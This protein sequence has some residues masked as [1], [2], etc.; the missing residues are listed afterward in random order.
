MYM[1]LPI[2][3]LN[4]QLADL[5]FL[6]ITD[7]GRLII[8]G[9]QEVDAGEYTCIASNIAGNTSGVVTLEVGCKYATNRKTILL[10][11]CPHVV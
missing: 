9:T 5:S 11:V 1:Q 4:S 2:T 6:S 8:Y 10:H 7:D 3:F